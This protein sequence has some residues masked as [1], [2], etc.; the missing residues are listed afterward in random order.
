MDLAAD[1]A[2]NLK[3]LADRETYLGAASQLLM[4]LF[5]S[6]HTA[7]NSLDA[8]A[9]TA[10]VMTYPYDSRANVPKM[11]L[12]MYSEHPLLASL[13]TGLGREP[14]PL[15]LSDFISDLELYNSRAFQEGLSLLCVNRQLIL[16]TACTSFSVFHCWSMNRWNHDFSDNEVALA[17]HVQPI[18]QLLDS[19]Y[20]ST[21]HRAAEITGAQA[22]SLTAREQEVM[23]LLGQGLKA[24]AI[25]RV[26]GCS[27]RTVAK[28][29]EHAYAKLGSNNRINALRRLRGED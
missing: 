26:L 25:G 21:P 12:D 18:L 5:P 3:N 9:G 2:A 13:Q 28:H 29:I 8:Q 16:F 17:Q 23:R 22:Y 19:A 11:L 6:D 15:R 7:W 27:P 20:A 14:H 10:E 24:I 1:F 4:K